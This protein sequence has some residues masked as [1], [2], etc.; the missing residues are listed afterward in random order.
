MIGN[1]SLLDAAKDFGDKWHYVKYQS[2]WIVV[3]TGVMFLAFKMRTETLQKIAL[4]FLVGC[5]ISLVLVL[6][7]GIGQK[8]LG[9]RRWLSLFGF[10]FQPSELTK[11]GL[12]IY[13]AKLWT[14]K[15][16][17]VKQTLIIVGAI[18]CL[19][20]F[21]PDMGSAIII[22]LISG[23]IIWLGGI[24]TQVINKIVLGL[25]GACTLLIFVSP[26]RLNR[27]KVF[28]DYSIDPLGKSYHIRQS[29]I[30]FGS[31]GIFGVGLG[32]SRQKYDF[33]PESMTDSI[34]AVVAEEMG[35]IGTSVILLGYVWLFTVGI[36]VVKQEDGFNRLLATGLTVW[37][38]VQAML[39]IS[40]MVA[41]IPLTGIP[42]PFLSYGGSALIMNMFVM[43][44]L[45]KMAK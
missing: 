32:Q 33:L 44:L 24:D 40:A 45:A 35:F 21:Q 38:F 29:L 31:G 12:V 34:F 14:S 9:A 23:A 5:L 43:G 2:M 1:A 28:F 26:Y 4:L 30:A 36:S 20:M 42:L 25:L 19:V 16:N 39:N 13:L 22:T 41:L 18:L 10:S 11:L 7:P 3:G 27:L 6:I 17:P 15:K 8:V 37:L